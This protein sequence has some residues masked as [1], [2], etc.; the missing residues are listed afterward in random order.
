[1]PPT[2]VS[3][4]ISDTFSYTITDGKALS[5]PAIVTI[6]LSAPA[7]PD[8]TVLDDFNRTA[9]AAGLG[10]DWAQ[11][12]SGTVNVQLDGTQAVV[13]AT[14]QGGQATWVRDTDPSPT[15]DTS[16]L[17]AT[18]Y[19]AFTTSGSLANLGLILKA[20]G[21]NA[22]EAPTNFVRVRLE[23]SQ[24]VVSTQVGG[25]NSPV[26]VKQAAFPASGTT[27]TLSAVVDAK[28]LVT[29]FLG[30]TF[31]GGVQLPDVGAWKGTG[32]IG[33]Q[34]QNLNATVDNFAGGTL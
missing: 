1:V 34:L 8:T 28:G 2:A 21:G 9:S 11:A 13:A 16:I 29:V 31:Q 12:S 33:L 32:R 15:V 5:G 14:D 26:Y 6:S 25:S 17:G 10:T 23:G 30:T 4:A 24:F 3:G 22:K 19:A 18:Q 20:T 27:G 7:A